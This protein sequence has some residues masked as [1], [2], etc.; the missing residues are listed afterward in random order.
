MT[1]HQCISFAEDIEHEM[2]AVM[3]HTLAKNVE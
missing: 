2:P 1:L 3:T